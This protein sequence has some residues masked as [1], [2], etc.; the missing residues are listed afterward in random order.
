MGLLGPV[1]WKHLSP[2]LQSPSTVHNWKRS[3]Q[4]QPPAV[5][6]PPPVPQGRAVAH[7]VHVLPQASRQKPW[8]AQDFP[9]TNWLGA[10]HFTS[11]HPS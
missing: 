5:P 9:T 6:P 10:E 7:G 4:P 2:F 8:S 1:S 11:V 3:R